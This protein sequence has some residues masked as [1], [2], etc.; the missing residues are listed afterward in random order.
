MITR[1]DF[2]ERRRQNRVAIKEE[3]FVELYKPRLF[4]LGKPRI[5]NSASIIDISS[6]GLSFQY[7]DRHMWSPDSY[8]LSISTTADK[9]KIEGVPFKAVSDYPISRL[10]NSK[11]IRR[12]GVKFGELTQNKKFQLDH[13]IKNHTIVDR[14]SGIERRQFSYSTHSPDLRSSND[15]RGVT[16]SNDT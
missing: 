13:L 15:R 6:G 3:A 8:E 7:T 14:R 2:V 10:S 11:F 1:E 4:K 5:A 16:A 9:R 12:R